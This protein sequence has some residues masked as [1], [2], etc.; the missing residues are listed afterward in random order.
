MQP[1]NG[2]VKSQQ[3]HILGKGLGLSNLEE[4]KLEKPRENIQDFQGIQ[5]MFYYKLINFSWER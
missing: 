5:S 4:E 3:T 2:E 1:N